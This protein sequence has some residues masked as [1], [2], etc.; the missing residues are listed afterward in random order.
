MVFSAR[1]GTVPT[2]SPILYFIL[3]AIE[4]FVALLIVSSVN[5]LY[6]L[7]HL[8]NIIFNRSRDEFADRIQFFSIK[9]FKV[10]S[11]F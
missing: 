5:F 6:F 8:F 3:C 10:S 4:H 9:S 11:A 2:F 7:K 1:Q